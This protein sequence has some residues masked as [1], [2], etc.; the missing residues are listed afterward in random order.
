MFVFGVFAEPF[1]FIIPCV[2]LA[3]VYL[4]FQQIGF[5]SHNLL[6]LVDFTPLAAGACKIG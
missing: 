2:S 4:A 6:K 1:I 5:V 3:Y